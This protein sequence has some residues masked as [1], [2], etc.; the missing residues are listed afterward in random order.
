MGAK[1]KIFS[2]TATMM[3]MI[4]IVVAAIGFVI[5]MQDSQ[6]AKQASA[7]KS[8]GVS[9]TASGNVYV[10]KTKTKMLSD[11]NDKIVFGASDEETFKALDPTSNIVLSSSN[12]YVVFE[13]VFENNSN[14]VSFVTKMTNT[15]VIDNM[16]VTYGYSYTKLSTFESINKQEVDNVPLIKGES[17]TLYYYIKAKVANLNKSCLLSGAFCFSLIADEVYKLTLVD[18]SLFN[19]VYAALGYKLNSVEVP[20]KDGYKFEGYFT[21]IA[22]TGEMIFDQDGNSD[23]VWSTAGGDVLYAYYTKI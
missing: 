12:D 13:Y 10:G 14:D 2:A 22:G 16:D 1:K 18:G 23:K 5:F 19:G 15:A 6:K 9:A 7:F 3:S 11:N 21:G 4:L 8:F 17:N 20:H